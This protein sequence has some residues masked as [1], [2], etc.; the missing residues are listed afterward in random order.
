MLDFDSLAERRAK[1]LN[2]EEKS[3][4]EVIWSPGFQKISTNMSDGEVE[5]LISL[6][7]SPHHFS[8]TVEFLEEHAKNSE[9]P[10][11]SVLT[12]EAAKAGLPLGDWVLARVR[13]RS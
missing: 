9:R 13:E 12:D 10:P 4:R 11:F 7:P 5:E 3:W 1:S 8:V 2:Q 6:C